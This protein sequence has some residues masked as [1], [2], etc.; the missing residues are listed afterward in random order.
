MSESLFSLNAPRAQRKSRFTLAQDTIRAV[1]GEG[2]IVA[3]GKD[4]NGVPVVV[5]DTKVGL[6]AV[7]VADVVTA[8]TAGAIPLADLVTVMQGAGK[9]DE[10]AT[11]IAA[12]K[13]A[14]E[15]KPATA[16]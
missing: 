9:L 4:G 14:A 10:L 2:G 12:A 13:K 6:S 11:A 3:L 16:K 15:P 7:P 8:L 1:D 5:S